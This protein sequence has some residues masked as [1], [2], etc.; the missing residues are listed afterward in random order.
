MDNNLPTVTTIEGVR[1]YVDI[2]NVAWLNVEDVARGLGFVMTRNDRVTTRG[3]NYS[4]V[5]WNRV[6]GYLAEFGYSKEVSKDDFI[7]EN[8]FYRLAMKASNAAAQAFQAKVADEIL[9]SIRK[10]GF[11]ATKPVDLADQLM[12][13]AKLNIEVRNRLNSIEDTVQEQAETLKR[14]QQAHNGITLRHEM[15]DIKQQNQLNDHE[16]KINENTSDIQELKEAIGDK[17]PAEEV[18]TLISEI[19]VFTADTDKP[20]SY[21]EAY[22]LFYDTLRQNTGIRICTRVDNLKKRLDAKGLSKTK[23]NKIS[24]LDAITADPMIWQRVRDVI[25]ILKGYLVEAKN[26]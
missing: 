26:G 13:Q 25:D 15:S 8:M 5:R 9:P 19:V 10:T 21:Q 18:K 2:N 17:G 3:D 20:Y 4:A 12:I 6:N 23:V 16:V 1:C 11:Y 7:P 14:L 24:G 22:K